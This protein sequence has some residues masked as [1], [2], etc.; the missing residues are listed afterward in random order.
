MGKAKGKGGSAA[1][2]APPKCIC[3]HPFQCDCGNRPERPSKGH[4]WYPAD[5][6]WAGKGHKQK[7]A[8]GQVSSVSEQAKITATGK[9]QVS[10]WQ[11]LPSQ[12]LEEVCK[13]Q[14]RLTPKY[15]NV[16]G[17]AAASANSVKS[18][19]CRVILCDPR[20][21]EKDL[22]FTPAHAV[23]NEE[24]AKEEGAL[25]ALLQLTPSLP[26]ERK[27]PEPYKTT[28]LN[29]IQS[30]KANAKPT[31]KSVP[32]SMNNATERTKVDEM[33]LTVVTSATATSSSAV[34][35][36]NLV[37][38]ATYSSSTDR[39]RQ[40]EERRRLQNAR[41]RKHDAIRMANRNHP[42]F[43]SAFMRKQVERLLRG[44]SQG[45]N[46]ENTFWSADSDDED[47]NTMETN[48][49]ST[50]DGG[51]SEEGDALVYVVH[52]LRSEG[53]SKRPSRAAY[54]EV[55]KQNPKFHY[56]DQDE[57]LWDQLYE[58]CLQ[59]LLVHLN[60]DQLPEGFDPRGR[61]LDVI[62]PTTSVPSLPEKLQSLN[63]TP[64]GSGKSI[65]DTSKEFAG[66]HGI[67]L[68]EAS[69]VVELALKENVSPVDV[70]M[71]TVK[72]AAG[73]NE[74]AAPVLEGKGEI[75]DIL[76]DEMEALSAIFDTD[77][78]ISSNDNGY[79]LVCL[80][81]DDGGL[82]LEIT[83]HDVLYPSVR[84]NSVVVFGDWS[85]KVGVALHI[86]L[87][88]F[89]EELPMEEPMIFAIHAH[90]QDLVQS[91]ELGNLSLLAYF[92]SQGGTLNQKL[93]KTNEPMPKTEK[94]SVKDTMGSTATQT[95]R[96]RSTKK[97]FWSIH[98]RD[99]PPAIA[100]PKVG[101]LM[102][103]TRKSLPAAA[104]RTEFL[105]AMKTA[106]KQGTRVVLVTGE[107]GSG[108]CENMTGFDFWAQKVGSRRLLLFSVISN[109]LDCTNFLLQGKQ[110]NS[111][112]T[113]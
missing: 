95:R 29:A 7:G 53:F 60:E 34:A 44:D 76:K 112:L 42:V 8:S 48:P 110:R 81:L 45:C 87:A 82:T 28:W 66:L 6:I 20:D 67:T 101:F 24:Q 84:P 63:S 27:L 46:E 2:T 98:P 64:A 111:L 93:P 14:G 1:P 106:N 37:M 61:T 100:L 83:V 105:A 16:G 92:R 50:A 21:S 108:K 17:N 77:C 32:S 69:L 62:L 75:T 4:K 19:K 39:R 65:N 86:E 22:F 9:T 43:M 11:R 12:L 56:V 41:I 70:F 47:D 3:D 89:T 107:T 54:Q 57:V 109:H 33:N 73:V 52:R 96:Y 102:D 30:Q 79:S 78:N 80:K 36:S 35:S 15:K 99:T 5:Q 26:H 18:Y 49:A 10:Q 72:S 51:I 113:F 71:R 59:W 97:T 25:L 103:R 91:G 13:K 58:Q 38:A 40:I 88:K 104:A 68:H 94:V 23:A 74:L 31:S 85:S 55:V 90:A